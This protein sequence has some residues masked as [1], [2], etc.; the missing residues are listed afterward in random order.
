M[1]NW[2]IPGA[3]KIYQM[4]PPT[5]TLHGGTSLPDSV[6]MNI[7]TNHI[8]L[9]SLE[10][11]EMKKESNATKEDWLFCIWENIYKNLFGAGCKQGHSPTVFLLKKYCFWPPEQN[12]SNS[13]TTLRDVR[14]FS[15]MACSPFLPVQGGP[16]AM[17]AFFGFWG[18]QEPIGE[19]NCRRWTWDT[20]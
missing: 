15:S 10:R 4:I 20:R 9:T 2:A 8:A 12:K 6:F 5:V 17:R 1:S 13:R 7:L 16:F 14:T 3:L 11:N 19:E 18:E